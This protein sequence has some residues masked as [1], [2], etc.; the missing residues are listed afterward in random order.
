MSQIRTYH[1]ETGSVYEIDDESK[2]VRRLCGVSDPTPR[3]GQG[4][5]QE[6][7]D[8]YLDIFGRLVIIWGYT[9][10]DEG[11]MAHT[12]VTSRVVSETVPNAMQVN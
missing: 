10:T 9:L 7:E 2:T 4:E 5:W 3:M 6:F 11:R 12:T 8:Y 1:T